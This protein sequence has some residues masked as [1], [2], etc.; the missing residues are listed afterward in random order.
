MKMPTKTSV[1]VVL[2][3]LLLAVGPAMFYVGVRANASSS[4]FSLSPNE[5]LS[6]SQIIF[7]SGFENGFSD[8]T[9]T[10]G[11]PSLVASPVYAG[12]YAM[13]CSD[14]YSS[15]AVIRIPAQNTVFAEGE[16]RI[17]QNIAG[18]ITLI[19]FSD[20]T[21]N[22]LASAAISFVNGHSQVVMENYQP[23]YTYNSFQ[24]DIPANAWFTLGLYV[25]PDFTVLYYNDVAVR[26]I[27]QAATPAINSVGVGMFWGTGSYTG[28]LYVDNVQVGGFLTSS[29]VT[30]NP[31]SS[32]NPSPTP[33][34][35]SITPTPTPTLAPGETPSPTPVPTS[36]DS[37]SLLSPE[38]LPETLMVSGP[39]ISVL[40]AF[41]LVLYNPKFFGK[42]H[43]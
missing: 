10:G 34:P 35:S 9:V 16:F 36:D 21:D 15:I 2:L 20:A 29:T 24:T 33:N 17:D 38:R 1:N 14:Q 32:M 37:S 31:S 5:L 28:N 7:A 40:A 39:A 18:Q 3:I 19:R 42:T 43:W 8:W 27:Y 12:S 22:P 6:G 30:P 13:K 26:T 23:S 25:T 4:S 11:M 41:A